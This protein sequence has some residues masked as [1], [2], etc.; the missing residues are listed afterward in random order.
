VN[1][2]I[3]IMK[4]GRDQADN[5]RGRFYEENRH[6]DSSGSSRDSPRQQPQQPKKIMSAVGVVNQQPAH[7]FENSDNT[8]A[9]DSND[10]P[11]TQSL[12]S[13]S[14]SQTQPKDKPSITVNTA[15]G[16]THSRRLFGNLM[17]HL[18]SARKKLEQDSE[19]IE[20]QSLVKQEALNKH[21]AEGQKLLEAQQELHKL[22]EEK[23]ILTKEVAT[24]QSRLQAI[25][26]KTESWETHLKS[27][28]PFLM[29][30]F[31]HFDLTGTSCINGV[32]MQTTTT[33]RL[34]WA[35]ARPS[36]ITNALMEARAADIKQQRDE[37]AISDEEQRS[38]LEPQLQTAQ[39]RLAQVEDE[40]ANREAENASPNSKEGNGNHAGGGAEKHSGRASTVEEN[41]PRTDIAPWSD[42]PTSPN[43]RDKDGNKKLL[44]D[45][46]AARL[47]YTH[48]SSGND[49]NRD[50]DRDRDRNN[51]NRGRE[52]DR[53]R[54]TTDKI[55]R[56]GYQDDDGANSRK[57][58]RIDRSSGALDSGRSRTSSRDAADKED[59]ANKDNDNNTV[60]LAMDGDDREGDQLL[61]YITGQT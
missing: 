7:N 43:G 18:G 5:N 24:L 46:W 6:Q 51:S 39:A 13:Q 38:A 33:P 49:S 36:H 8:D 27:T 11:N 57:R 30:C 55:G 4:R 26:T 29:V 10:H 53:S 25:Q 1:N 2:N 14:S 52:W 61:A 17:Q 16:R 32:C 19:K 3:G 20:Q 56:E 60:A 42:V 23:V 21:I 15:E 59:E 22:K 58:G 47:G 45:R 50:R 41:T 54:Q 40:L 37:R 28:E 48:T 9:T 12:A 44:S 31:V 34:T 35:P